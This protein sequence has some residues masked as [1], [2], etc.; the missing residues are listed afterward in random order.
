MAASSNNK[1]IISGS[2]K[3]LSRAFSLEITSYS[4]LA[5]GLQVGQI[6]AGHLQLRN[7]N[8]LQI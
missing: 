8:Q 4:R 1:D 5:T 6:E 7:R 3:T 2:R